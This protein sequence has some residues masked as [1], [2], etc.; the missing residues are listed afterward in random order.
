MKKHYLFFAT[1]F[2]INATLFQ[3]D[4]TRN[5]IGFRNLPHHASLLKYN[6]KTKIYN[7][8]TFDKI[9]VNEI[10][11]FCGSKM[12]IFIY[13]Y[14]NKKHLVQ[15]YINYYL[16]DI[17]LILYDVY[18]LK[19]FKFY[20]QMTK[21]CNVLMQ[22]KKSKR[23]FDIEQYII[24]A[25]FY[26]EYVKENTIKINY[27]KKRHWLHEIFDQE[28]HTS[29]FIYAMNKIYRDRNLVPK[30]LLEV[31]LP[32][33]TT[34][35]ELLK[36]VVEDLCSL[37]QINFNEIENIFIENEI[38]IVFN[39]KCLKYIQNFYHFKLKN[40]YLQCET[41]ENIKFAKI[42]E[43]KIISQNMNAQA[44]EYFIQIE[45][46]QM[47][48]IW[49]QLFSKKDIDFF[50]YAYEHFDHEGLYLNIL[51]EECNDLD[52]YN[53]LL[54]K[55]KNSKNLNINSN[56]STSTIDWTDDTINHTIDRMIASSSSA[57]DPTSFI[58]F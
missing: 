31:I 1:K 2:I 18:D 12:V 7:K 54:D 35:F 46:I 32:Q 24:C 58:L 41:I 48:T 14:F 4:L 28:N 43:M 42:N 36:F 8:H 3:C 13:K 52:I 17:S 50:K 27:R 19:L 9:F 25:Q 15:M 47:N 40:T 55:L 16:D 30:N 34:N 11:K 33:I 10:Y 29:K 6:L 39:M 56:F 37:N 26:V 51:L 23:E 20:C 57:A 53:F 21:E 45:N 5:K 38:K 22:V 44:A 49:W